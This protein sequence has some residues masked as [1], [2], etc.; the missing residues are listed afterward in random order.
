MNVCH[1]IN[2]QT[3]KHCVSPSV[4]SQYIYTTN[5]HFPPTLVKLFFCHPCL[6]AKESCIT[7]CYCIKVTQVLL[8][9]MRKAASAVWSAELLHIPNQ[10]MQ[11]FKRG[12]LHICPVHDLLNT[13]PHGSVKGISRFQDVI[14]YKKK[15]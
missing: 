2:L 8:F 3:C 14:L 7:F 5:T 4:Q 9:Y 15:I 6:T 11:C 1:V 13:V 10:P 12:M